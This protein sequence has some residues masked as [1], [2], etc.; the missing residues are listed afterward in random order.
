MQHWQSDSAS[1]AGEDQELWEVIV[2]P[3]D[4]KLLTLEQLDDAFRLDVI[5]VSTLVRQKGTASWQ[6]LGVVAGI[7]NEAPNRAPADW[8]DGTSELPPAF[9]V[10]PEPRPGKAPA[11]AA[12]AHPFWNAGASQPPLPLL[13]SPILAAPAAPQPALEPPSFDA[14]TRAEPIAYLGAPRVSGAGRSRLSSAL[15][16]LCAVAGALW[17]VHRNDLL[18]L[19]ARRFG[20]ETKYL[21]FEQSVLGKPGFGTPRALEAFLAELPGEAA[22]PNDAT[23]PAATPATNAGSKHADSAP[24]ATPPSSRPRSTDSA[25][26][27]SLDALP[28]LPANEPA[29]EAPAAPAPKAPASPRAEA[30]APRGAPAAKPN[31][32]ITLDEAPARPQKPEDPLKAAI[33]SAIEKQ[34]RKK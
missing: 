23:P 7:E 6:R 28:V 14:L 11:Y 34:N 10:R 24:A 15:M 26:A 32:K 17:I 21:T 19:G 20:F 3:D 12:A 25:K 4:I 27:V 8:S 31:E 29:R 22:A 16:L 1:A 33:R 30:P 2:A 9:G 18:R 5:G 13:E